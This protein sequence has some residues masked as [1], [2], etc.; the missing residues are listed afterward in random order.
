MQTD[1]RQPA[2]I[3]YSDGTID[4]LIP[5]P[6]RTFL[7][8]A[9]RLRAFAEGLTVMPG[10]PGETEPAGEEGGDGA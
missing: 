2:L 4:Q 6:V 9:D 5:L 8:A 10:R 7:A 1:D 3:L